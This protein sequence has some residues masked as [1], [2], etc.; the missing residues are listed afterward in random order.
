VCHGG[1]KRLVPLLPNCLHVERHSLA[2]NAWDQQPEGPRP[3]GAGTT[4]R[5]ARETAER[6][7]AMSAES[8]EMGRAL[9]FS[10]RA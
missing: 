8:L 9:R 10:E 1:R 2:Q 7:P 5:G 6:H 3:Q 4:P